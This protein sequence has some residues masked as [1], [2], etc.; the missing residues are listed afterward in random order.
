MGAREEEISVIL[1]TL[2]PF[3]MWL[4]S[5]GWF[6]VTSKNDELNCS[7]LEVLCVTCINLQLSKMQ[8]TC[9]FNPHFQWD[10]ICY[11]FIGRRTVLNKKL[12]H[13]RSCPAVVIVIVQIFGNWRCIYNGSNEIQNKGTS[14]K[15]QTLLKRQTYIINMHR[16][17]FS[18][19]TK[20]SSEIHWTYAVYTRNVTLNYFCLLSCFYL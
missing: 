7:Y 12:T 6:L 14:I 3:L 17:L 19:I 9:N 5:P 13:W 16:H 10:F 20:L 1:K 2:L 4:S 8:N 15:T 11:N 18:N